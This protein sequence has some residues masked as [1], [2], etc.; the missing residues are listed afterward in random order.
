MSDADPRRALPSVD[1]LLATEPAERWAEAY[2]RDTVRGVFRRAL[3]VVRSDPSVLGDGEPLG[4]VLALAGEQLEAVV[5]PSLRPVINGTGVVLHTNLGRS[6]LAEE[7]VAAQTAVAGYGNVEFSL[8]TGERGS[9]YD[10]C[11]GLLRELTGAEAAVVTNNNAAAVSLCV[12]EFALDREAIVSRGELVEI[13]GSFRIPDVVSR[14]GSVLREVGTTN[15][16]RIEDYSDAIGDLTGVILRV[17][18]SNYRVEGFADRPDIEALVGVANAG[19]VPLVHDIGSGLL[20]PDLLP[21]FPH[22]PSVSE[23][24]SAGADLVTFSGDKLLGGP[25]AGMIVGRS[26]LVDRLRRNPLL[27]AFRVDKTTL[28]AL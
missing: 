6:C 5:Q 3:D 23:S 28:A 1:V 26:D 11:A 19:G 10:H 17:H 22:E 20:A 21:A 4:V 24:V 7:A 18:P 9:R 8:S 25:Q 27:R 12:N 14:S 16:T 15:R 2:G 13:G